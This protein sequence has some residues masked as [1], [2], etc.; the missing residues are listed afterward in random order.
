MRISCI[1]LR[2]VWFVLRSRQSSG[3]I[4][5][6]CLWAL[7]SIDLLGASWVVEEE[8]AVW[9]GVRVARLWLVNAAL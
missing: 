4:F 2:S 1:A 9:V 8:N 7:F 5:A 6:L 3:V